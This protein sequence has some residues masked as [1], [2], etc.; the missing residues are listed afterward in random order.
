MCRRLR[1][2]E[3]RMSVKLSSTATVFD[4]YAISKKFTA[5]QTAINMA[6]GSIDLIASRS[7]IDLLK[8]GDKTIYSWL[9]QVALDLDSI[10]LAVS[11]S[12]YKDINGVLT[13]I[14]QAQA[15]IKINSGN[16]ALKVSKNNIIS[17]INQSA[18]FVSIDAGKIN[19]NGIVTANNHFKILT[20]GSMVASAG[21]IG[22]WNI[23][24][25]A[26]FKDVTISDGTTYRVYFQPPLLTQATKTWVLSCQE[27]KSDTSTFNANFILYSDGSAKFGTNLAISKDGSISAS[28]GSFSGYVNATSG[29]FSG[30]LR[31]ATGSFSGSVTTIK[32]SKKSILNSGSLFFYSDNI[33]TGRFCASKWKTAP[34]YLGVGIGASDGASYISFGKDDDE[35][36][37]TVCSYLINYGLNPNGYTQQNIFW[38]GIVSNGSV[39][40]IGNISATG[41]KN[42]AIKT[43]KYGWITQ[44]AYETAEPLFG[45]IGHE[46]IDDNGKCVINIDPKF[47]DTVSTEYG[48]Y[49]FLAGYGSGNLWVDSKGLNSFIVCGD[50]GI[51]FDWEIKCHQKGYENHRLEKIIGFE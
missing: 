33:Q 43:K 47:L 32:G 18:E 23:N 21:Q 48:Y 35:A 16:I 36:D 6:Q 26:I 45:D 25:T 49:V 5:Q 9:S 10:T 24:N 14:S 13:A 22:G 41:V 51:E 42:R 38:G 11:S 40:I 2:K 27:K 29:S 19:L 34:D 46:K 50:P 7:E 15:S 1:Q 37:A 4:R 20:D 39:Y 17:S 44:N 12:E 28:N 3:G 8:N 31:A 30:M